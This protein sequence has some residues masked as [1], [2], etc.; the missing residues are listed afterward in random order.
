MSRCDHVWVHSPTANAFSDLILAIGAMQSYT[1][2]SDWYTAVARC[3]V[4]VDIHVAQCQ[5]DCRPGEALYRDLCQA[6][7]AYCELVEALLDASLP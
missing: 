2:C 1:D 3:V 7:G 6:A 5:A 4:D